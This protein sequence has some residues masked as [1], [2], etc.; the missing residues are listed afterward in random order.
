MFKNAVTFLCGIGF[1]VLLSLAVEWNT[2]RG[3]RLARAHECEVTVRQAAAGGKWTPVR[4][5]K[6]QTAKR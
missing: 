6:M 3:E 5:A 4:C 2:Q 1:Y